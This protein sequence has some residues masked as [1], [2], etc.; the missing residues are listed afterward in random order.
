MKT[1]KII[2]KSLLVII[3]L[4]IIFLF[5]NQNGAQTTELTNG[6]LERILWFIDN[7]LTFIIIRKLAHLTEYLILGM[8]IYNLMREFTLKQIILYSCL[9]CTLLAI[10][11]EIHQLFVGGRDGKILDVLIDSIG[12]IC[13]IFLI[14]RFIKRLSK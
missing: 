5:S 11:D 12:S 10:F 9:I 13:G 8:L 4:C 7:D 3:W 14:N 6:L 1:F 2:Y